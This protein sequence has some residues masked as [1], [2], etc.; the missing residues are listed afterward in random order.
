[1]V[2]V[3]TVISKRNILVHDFTVD[4]LMDTDFKSWDSDL[5]K[6]VFSED[7]V[8]YIL[9]MSLFNHSAND[10]LICILSEVRT[11]YAL[12]IWLIRPI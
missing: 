3:L 11:S 1:M 10:K 8:T 7:I 5:M 12:K 4:C 9:N 6:Q 2:V